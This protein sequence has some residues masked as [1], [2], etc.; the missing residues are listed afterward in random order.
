MFLHPRSDH[1]SYYFITFPNTASSTCESC[2]NYILFLLIYLWEARNGRC[3]LDQIPKYSVNSCRLILYCE[4][5]SENFCAKKFFLKCC[6]SM[7][8]FRWI[9]LYFKGKESLLI[10][11][12]LLYLL[13]IPRKL[14]NDIMLFILG[15]PFIICILDNP[16]KFNTTYEWIR[17]MSPSC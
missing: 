1:S 3:G 17:G 10:T 8:L 14:V 13:Y 6:A 12:S 5:A 9:Y 11:K 2:D 16:Y 7:K 4:S 15:T